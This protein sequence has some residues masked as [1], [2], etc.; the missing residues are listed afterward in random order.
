[1]HRIKEL[2]GWLVKFLNPVNASTISPV[3]PK[4]LCIL[5]QTKPQANDSPCNALLVVASA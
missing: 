3:N 1:M 4:V 5:I 2:T